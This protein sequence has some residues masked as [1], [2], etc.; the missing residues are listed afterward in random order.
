M[1]SRDMGVRN[2]IE[3]SFLTACQENFHARTIAVEFSGG[4]AMAHPRLSDAQKKL[5]GTFEPA[6]SEL[7]LIN[8]R[9]ALLEAVPPPSDL[10]PVA[11][12]EWR[13]H[14]AQC[15][16]ART[17]SHVNLAAFR[18]LAEAAAAR[19]RAYKLAIKQGPAVPTADGGSKT[20]AAWA[21]YVAADAAYQRWCAAFALT[22][23]AGA[24]LPQLPVPGGVKLRSVT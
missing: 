2:L 18:A 4:F 15:V 6:R 23:K 20:N 17:I 7:N 5:K 19:S 3:T 22:P 14:M 13:V 8:G 10:D 12:Q 21:G 9:T 11:Q 24:G 1:V 16:A